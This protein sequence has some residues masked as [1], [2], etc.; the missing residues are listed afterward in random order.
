MQTIAETGLHVLSETEISDLHDGITVLQE[1]E[2]GSVSGGFDPFGVLAVIALGVYVYYAWQHWNDP[3]SSSEH[4][5][6]SVKLPWPRDDLR[7]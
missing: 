2:V 1:S 6:E 4:W 5:W 3:S 7:R